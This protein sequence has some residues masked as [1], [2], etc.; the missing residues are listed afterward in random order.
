MRSVSRDRYIVLHS[1]SKDS[2]FRSLKR[3]A[4]RK[5]YAKDLFIT[6]M[7]MYKRFEGERQLPEQMRGCLFRPVSPTELEVEQTAEYLI[8][9]YKL[10]FQLPKV[11][12]P[13]SSKPV[14]FLFALSQ[15]LRGPEP[16]A[17]RFMTEH[18]A[19]CVRHVNSILIHLELMETSPVET[20]FDPTIRPNSLCEG[21]MRWLRHIC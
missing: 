4:L 18:A 11:R 9:L 20:I 13:G 6:Q 3:P 16:A 8:G 21:F 14:E 7:R 5:E 1:S 12:V 10:D 15:A 2:H 17:R 19:L